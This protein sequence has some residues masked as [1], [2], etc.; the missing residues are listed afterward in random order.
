MSQPFARAKAMLALM[1]VL[2]GN[3]TA[4]AMLPPYVSRGKGRGGPSPR[5]IRK[6]GKYSPHQGKQECERRL[7]RGW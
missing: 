1:A 3:I 7:A 5:F 2:A 6:A 4:L